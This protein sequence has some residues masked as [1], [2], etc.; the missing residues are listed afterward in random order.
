LAFYGIFTNSFLSQKVDSLV[1]A[2]ISTSGVILST[3]LEALDLDYQV[4]VLEDCVAD[5]D[6]DVH[7]ALIKLFRKRANVTTSEEYV[8]SLSQ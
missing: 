5:D 1:L 6:K 7:D 2:G 3:T 8:K 4:T